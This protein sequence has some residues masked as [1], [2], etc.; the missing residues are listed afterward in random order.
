ML[1][2]AI[3]AIGV[4]VVTLVCALGAGPA[5]LLAQSQ[6]LPSII[7]ISVDTLRADRLG[8]YGYRGRP[9]PNIDTLTKGGTLFAQVNAQVPLTLPSHVSLFTSS[10]PFSNGIVDNGQQLGP[11]A[12]TL[13]SLLKSKGY[14]TAAFVGG[15]VL[16]RRF[17]LHQG[18][19]V[20][21]SPFDLRR[22][23]GSDPGE[24]KRWG[25][26]VMRAAIE[27]LNRKPNGPFF[28]FL[29]LYDLHTPYGLPPA[30]RGRY[31]GKVSYETQIAY[32]DEVLGEFFKY[33][34]Q[35]KLFDNSLIVFTSDHG[36]GLGDHG[37]S[38]HGYFIYQ[39]TLHVPLIIHWPLGTKRLPDRI[40]VPARLLDVAPTVVQFAGLT[41]P[42]QFQGQSLMGV[43]NQ[44]EPPAPIEIY[45]ESLYAYRHFGC[46][47]LQCLQ[48]GRYKY[49]DAPRP[50][51]YDL[52]KDPG[53]ADNRYD[54]EKSMAL[55][56]RER[57]LA[58]RSRF[59]S[60]RPET[61]QAL[62]PE[63]VAALSSLGYV[64]VSSPSSAVS[65]SRPDPK[66]RL[67]EFESQNHAI[68]LAFL[69]RLEESNTLLQQLHLK[70]PD[71]P[72]ISFS[73]GINQQRL[74][75]HEE[76]A[77]TF[78]DAL[79]TDPLNVLGH[80][81]LAVSLFALRK[82]DEA[83]KELQAVLAMAPYY[84]RAD[85]LLGTIWVQRQDY[86][87]AR[88]CFT[89]LLKY[90]PEDYTA[91]YNLGVLATIEGKWDEAERHLGLALKADPKSSEAYNTLGSLYLK[92]GELDQARE[93]F[94]KTISLDDKLA[95]SHYNLGLVLRRQ[96]KDE[97]AAQAFRQ[98]LALDPQFRAARE[99][100]ERLEGVSK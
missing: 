73:L 85:E 10:Y 56:L 36:E 86:G 27:W 68:S 69:G 64:S 20:Y 26:E 45:S 91:H 18:F 43:L 76:A 55:S 65:S 24:V 63:T 99:A 7:L 41:R 100:L 90:A 75:R 78:R 37:E 96:K 28:A 44:R 31:G 8:C 95:A 30:K 35:K 12:I 14:Q 51:L 22:Q 34:A 88:D 46:S 66:D 11:N 4:V 71:V 6:T 33:L 2:P 29:H 47:G 1:L 61:S 83:I 79:K 25:E 15:F 16:D 72:D 58:V 19:D 32:V 94:M 40:V 74:G 13:A 54:S 42:E 92:R 21:D 39:S 87:R 62:S 80:F 98:A 9:T 53:E 60:E 82:L 67:R 52:V 57:L 89:H 77:Q 84:T 81:N 70:L 49:I 50:E 23:K 93:A 5:I 59:R 3:E 97:A 17:G 38:T 48:L